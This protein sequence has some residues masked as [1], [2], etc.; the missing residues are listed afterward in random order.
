M[1]C[2]CRVGLDQLDTRQTISMSLTWQKTSLNGTGWVNAKYTIFV[3]FRY[4]FLFGFTVGCDLT[5]PF[6]SLDSGL[7]FRGLGLVLAMVIAWIWWLS[8]I[9]SRFQEMMVSS[10]MET[11]LKC[12]CT[13]ITMISHLLFS[14][15]PFY[16]SNG[17][18]STSAFHHG[19]YW[20]SFTI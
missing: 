16:V 3:C 6:L 4:A 2:C 15:M 18:P 5:I 7:L 10:C 14:G 13:I 20:I 19:F 12:I 11:F 9:L 17:T 8:V 1:R